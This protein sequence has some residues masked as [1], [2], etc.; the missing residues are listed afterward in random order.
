M[1][2]LRKCVVGG[3]DHTDVTKAPENTT[4]WTAMLFT[5]KKGEEEQAL[6]WNISREDDEFRFGHSELE[7][8]VVD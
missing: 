1:V 3:R 5:K 7:V 2:T 8:P 4:K 6:R